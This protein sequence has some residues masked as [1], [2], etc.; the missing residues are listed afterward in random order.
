MSKPDRNNGD[1][2]IN[3]SE[4]F[5]SDYY[6]DDI[7]EELSESGLY[8]EDN[9]STEKT[10][11]PEKG[12]GDIGTKMDVIKQ[13]INQKIQKIEQRVLSASEM[14][15][16][17]KNELLQ[18]I[19]KM[20]NS[21]LLMKF[22]TEEGISKLNDTFKEKIA[23]DTVKDKAFEE[24]YSQLES[25]K[26]NFVFSAIK[27]FVHDLLLFQDR[28]ENEI[29]HFSEL[30]GEECLKLK[31]FREELL[32]ILYRNDI[33]RIEPTPEGEKFNPEKSNAVE[34]VDTDDQSLDNTV[35]KVLKAGFKKGN[36]QLRPELVQIYKFN[37]K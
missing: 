4:I 25:Y 30:N 19:Q 14:I 2:E 29:N 28:I 35:K 22:E 37:S 31:S 7:I 18:T 20:Q 1:F 32:E 34:K 8:S 5:N 26:R 24:L 13:D 36:S 12:E 15:F 6:F 10:D 11:A 3:R 27:P 9:I 33:T 23:G 21:L 17:L 16:N